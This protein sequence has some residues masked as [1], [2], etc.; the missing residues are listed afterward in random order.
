MKPPPPAIVKTDGEGLFAV[1]LFTMVVLIEFSLQKGFDYILYLH[2]ISY[3]MI[4]PFTTHLIWRFDFAYVGDKIPH[5]TK[6][7]VI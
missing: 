6:S 5:R 2:E 4:K 1:I 7:K 3:T